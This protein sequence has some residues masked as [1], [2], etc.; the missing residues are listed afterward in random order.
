MSIVTYCRMMNNSIE[1]SEKGVNYANDASDNSFQPTIVYSI[2]VESVN[3]ILPQ[4]L[5]RVGELS[6]VVA[7]IPRRKQLVHECSTEFLEWTKTH[8]QE[9]CRFSKM[10]VDL[11]KRCFSAK[12]SQ[13]GKPGWRESVWR[14]FHEIRSSGDSVE[15][16][17]KAIILQ[18]IKRS[19]FQANGFN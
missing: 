2:L 13:V 5:G 11:L 16:S 19:N 17:S 18:H 7:G 12:Q 4:P 14:K 6:K 15:N 1:M 8:A 3:K 9:A 10:L